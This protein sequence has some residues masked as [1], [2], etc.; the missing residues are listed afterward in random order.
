VAIANFPCQYREKKDRRGSVE[1]FQ[2]GECKEIKLKSKKKFAADEKK[3]FPRTK[4]TAQEIFVFQQ[5]LDSEQAANS[6]STAY[7]QEKR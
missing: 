5:E 2:L 7:S 6:L 1:I 3:I 4:K